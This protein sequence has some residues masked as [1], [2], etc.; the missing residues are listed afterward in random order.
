MTG[1]DD[2][3]IYLNYLDFYSHPMAPA[4]PE[5]PDV[6]VGRMRLYSL[7]DIDF[8]KDAITHRQT[9]V[10]RN[11]EVADPPFVLHLSENGSLA[12][13]DRTTYDI[14]LHAAR[15]AAHRGSIVLGFDAILSANA[16]ERDPEGEGPLVVGYGAESA[17]AEGNAAVGAR[18]KARE[19]RTT[20]L[21]GKAGALKWGA[22]AIGYNAQAVGVE[23]VAI[24]GKKDDAGVP[25]AE[26]FP[27]AT[28]DTRCVAKADGAVQIG[29]GVNDVANSLQFR[30][31]QLL[32]GSGNVPRERIVEA[33]KTLGILD[34]EGNIPK[35]ILMAALIELGL[36]EP[37]PA[38]EE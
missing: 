34:A 15:L 26:T 13:F 21:G 6:E 7:N 23:S 4:L 10:F 1:P 20:A 24:G 38:P 32:D 12:L 18:S 35:G 14:P 29:P 25:P 16:S 22:T 36:V 3:K 27:G 28:G 19:S 5:L 9:V 2:D 33:L 30:G 8:Y 11:P 17:C 31:H 37:E